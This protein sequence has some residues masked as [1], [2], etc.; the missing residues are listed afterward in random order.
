MPFL[1]DLQGPDKFRKL[2]GLLEKRGH[3]ASRIDKLLG[4]NFLR[5]AGDVWG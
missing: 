1:P 5:F 2:A 3:S 4:L